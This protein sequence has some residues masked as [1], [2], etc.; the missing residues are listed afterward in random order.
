MKT[1]KIITITFLLIFGLLAIWFN[2]PTKVLYHSEIKSGNEFVENIL[3]YKDQT[4]HLPK[5]N[6]WVTLE[7]LNPIKPY[8]RFYP[9]YRTLDQD[10]FYLTFI[11]G[12]DPPYLQ[13]DTKTKKWEMK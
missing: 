3:K 5:E 7:K 2:L 11:R 10:D 9:E 4:G 6:D 8:E 1:L 12:F 13:Y